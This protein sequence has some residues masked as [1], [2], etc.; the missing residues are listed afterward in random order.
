MKCKFKFVCCSPFPRHRSHNIVY[1]HPF[2]H[3]SSSEVA[4]RITITEHLKRQL[5]NI[6]TRHLIT[7]F[8]HLCLSICLF[9][10]A[11]SPNDT[12][13]RDSTSSAA[14]GAVSPSSR[15]PIT[16]MHE[17]LTN[18]PLQSERELIRRQEMVMKQQ[19][20]ALGDIEK[21]VGRLKNQVHKPPCCTA[22]TARFLFQIMYQWP[23]SM[24][25]YLFL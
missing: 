5:V 18:N 12:T 14:S 1:W 22:H 7:I 21:G 19:D 24:L 15:A 13:P 10:T 11:L 4:R 3:S 23:I 6:F 8:I 20:L 25:L 9:K 16:L 2:L 17:S